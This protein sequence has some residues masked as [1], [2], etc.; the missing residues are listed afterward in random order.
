[1]LL[2]YK[3]LHKN[4]L[5]YEKNLFLETKGVV[6]VGFELSVGQRS[7]PLQDRR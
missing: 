3:M 2:L 6:I 5:F 1:M 4:F 7:L